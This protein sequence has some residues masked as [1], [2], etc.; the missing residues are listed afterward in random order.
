[1]VGL[2]AF[3]AVAAAAVPSATNLLA[4]VRD[5]AMPELILSV[6]ACLALLVAA[7]FGRE[8]QRLAGFA[9]L[10]GL[11]LAAVSV[12]SIW[13]AQGSALPRIGLGGMYVVDE[14]SLVFKGM[15]LA[16][17]A[18][19][20]ALS[21]RFLDEE[22]AERGEYYALVLFATI[23]MM[24]VP[25]GADLLSLFIALEL[26]SLS[27]YVLV[28]FL[29]GDRRSNEAAIK[30]FMLGAFSSG[31]LLYGMSLVYGVAGST[32]LV[33]LSAAL[34]EALAGDGDATLLVGVGVALLVAGVAFKIAAAPF[35][36]WAPD[37]YEG[38]PT[39]VAAFMSVGVK[40]ASFALLVRIFVDGL[41][42]IRVS[43]DDGWPGWEV[44]LGVLA[45]VA[46]TWGN[47]AALTQKNAKRLLA[48]SAVAHSGYALLG[49][50]AGNRMGY[51]GLVLYLVVYVA[52]NLGAFGVLIA[53]RRGTIA[54]DGIADFR[55]LAAKAPGMAALMTIFML[56]LGGIPPTAGFVGKFYLFAALVE[57]GDK[58]LVALAA[59][60]LVNTAIS[61]YYYLLFVKEMYS[62]AGDE[63]VAALAT[64][65]GLVVAVVV[66]GVL[67][68]A[69]GVY[70]QPVIAVS[71]AAAERLKVAPDTKP[72]ATRAEERTRQGGRE[73]PN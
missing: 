18:L 28:G 50:V 44:A 65:P 11:G 69:I 19:T 45:A 63:P 23:G 57:D 4:E 51:T 68:L 60:A 10:V 61:A 70:P 20:I 53:L 27:V 12:V 37:A 31:L 59:L 9:S 8:H 13:I 35:H 16:A 73:G 54:G 17:A 36:V 49:I 21:M 38:A 2:P 3:S 40:A 5:L 24:L 64:S 34:P 7:G 14:L 48:Y 62:D 46:M 72:A 26:M 25:S 47:L 33:D 41:G 22:H 15:A 52:M 56:G 39:P 67:T 43:V 6:F 66:S 30:Y 1:M 58:W 42:T 32:R 71:S 55:G 29:R